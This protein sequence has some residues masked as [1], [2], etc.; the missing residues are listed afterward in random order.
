MFCFRFS[1]LLILI[2]E[3]GSSENRIY[4][5]NVNSE[6]NTA[7][8]N[9]IEQC[10]RERKNEWM[11]EKVQ[12]Q[13]GVAPTIAM[14]AFFEFLRDWS[15]F[16]ESWTLFSMNGLEFVWSSPRAKNTIILSWL[17][18]SAFCITCFTT[19]Y[20]LDFYLIIQVWLGILRIGFLNHTTLTTIK[21][22]RVG[23]FLCGGGAKNEKEQIERCMYYW[24]IIIVVNSLP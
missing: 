4:F 11:S 17:P 2:Y 3:K 20:F 9:I 23:K 7:A 22:I 1:L 15:A 6:G 16:L 19:I 8:H 24:T 12:N 10:N 13:R 21:Y 5:L 18:L 14:F